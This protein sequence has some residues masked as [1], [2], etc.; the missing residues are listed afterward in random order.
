MEEK[1]L[2]F[3]DY[4]QRIVVPFLTSEPTKPPIDEIERDIKDMLWFLV[5]SFEVK[6]ES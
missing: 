2:T 6:G 5:L 4:L 3:E 1:P